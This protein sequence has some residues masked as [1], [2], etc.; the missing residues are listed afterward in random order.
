MAVYSPQTWADSPATSSPLS[1]ARLNHAEDGIAGAM[2]YYPLVTRTLS[3]SNGGQG[4]GL[5]SYL[6]TRTV[7][8]TNFGFRMGFR[9][10]ADATSYSVKLR[11]YDQY[12]S[13]NGAAA[14]T[15]DGMTIGA[16][17]AP[18][19]GAV[20]Q[21]GNFNGSTGTT[22][23]SSGTIPNTSSF[24]TVSGSGTL[25]EGTDYVLGI[26]FHAAASTTLLV[27]IG[28]CWYWNNSTSAH[29]PATAAS[30]ATSAAQFIPLDVVIEY[31]TTN[32]K[33]AVIVFGDSIPEGAQGI[34]YYA[35]GSANLQPTPLHL[36][37]L[38]QWA[39]RRG[40]VMLQ[41]HC[42]FASTAQ[43][44]ANSSYGG[45]SRMSTSG[46][47]WDAAFITL[48]CNDLAGGTTFSTLQGYYTSVI[49]NVRAIVGNSVPL[50]ALNIMPESFA[51]G[52][53]SKESY[54]Y[55]MDGWLSQLPAGVTACVDLDSAVRGWASTGG[56]L[57][58]N[59]MDLALSS[60]GIHPSY[61]GSTRLADAVMAAVQ[62]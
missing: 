50:Y 30:G 4:S 27:G 47:A 2:R 21:T 46:A 6:T 36:G 53:N 58:T 57:A 49:S 38:E 43:M 54:R 9:L 28:Q 13:A 40:D 16:M 31:T 29:N 59:T 8:G 18:S 17:T 5:S 48:G 34:N 51:T 22:L 60:D 25:T 33:R 15:L 44:W 55:N 1:A 41:R 11:N 3:Y 52:T 10:P 12:A 42:L 32:R 37:F 23:A 14:L 45:Y 39:R 56:A 7:T 61:Q 20:A 26:S 24:L 19:T 62:I 35:N